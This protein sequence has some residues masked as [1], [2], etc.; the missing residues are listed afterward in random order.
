MSP[1]LIVIGLG[2]MGSAVAYHAAK[3]GYRVLGI[4]RYSPPHVWGSTHGESRITREAIGEGESFVPLARRSHLLWRMLE[5]ETGQPLMHAC[6]GLILSHPGTA[7][8]MHGQEDFFGNTV[9]AAQRFGIPHEILDASAIRVRFSRFVLDGSEKGYF[10]P[11]AGWLNPEACI[12]ANLR[13]AKAMHA[14]LML[15]TRVLKIEVHSSGVSVETERGRHHGASLVIAAGA[16]LPQLAPSVAPGRLIVR[17]QVMHW[18]ADVQP[19]SNEPVFIWHWGAGDNDVFYGF[20][21]RDG[22]IKMAAESLSGSDDPDQVDR[23]VKPTESADFFARHMRHRIA[24][25]EP[26]CVRSATC[27]Y[28]VAPTSNFVVDT[29]PDHP[30]A[31]AVSAC[32]GHGFK[33]SA[34]IGEAVAEWIQNSERPG[35]LGPFARS[36]LPV[37]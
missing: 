14:E 36:K 16:W 20:P 26:R 4:D 24:G 18:F 8:R 17:R 37:D 23:D 27:L 30:N 35:I 3:R 5:A 2:A 9:R 29:L 7:S 13:R 25:V 28:T 33:H 11:G 22:A 21:G 1:D 15:D 10:E 6:G 12:S 19:A 31:I 32:S 34:A